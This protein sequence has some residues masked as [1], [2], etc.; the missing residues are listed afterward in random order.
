M[1]KILIK[2]LLATLVQL[3]IFSTPFS[4]K[5]SINCKG[6]CTL[7]QFI[8]G[9]YEMV[10]PFL[11]YIKFYMR[12]DIHSQIYLLINYKGPPVSDNRTLNCEGVVPSHIKGGETAIGYPL[13]TYT[14]CTSHRNPQL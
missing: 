2:S 3:G 6:A 14:M 4:D 1:Y 8:E 9:K 5:Q 7:S 13:S 11:I 12:K 10:C